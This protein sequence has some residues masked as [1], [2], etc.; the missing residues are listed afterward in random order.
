MFARRH[1]A[2]LGLLGR[3]VERR[4]AA[5]GEVEREGGEAIVLPADVADADAVERAAAA[6]GAA[7]NRANQSL[8][9]TAHPPAHPQLN[10]V[11]PRARTVR[12]ARLR[13]L[14]FNLPPS[15]L[16]YRTFSYVLTGS[17]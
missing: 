7:R 17:S 2:R 15:R 3:G 5:K 9:L 6:R 14:L 1:R 10:S 11:I 4:E 13:N 16:R 12:A 8:G